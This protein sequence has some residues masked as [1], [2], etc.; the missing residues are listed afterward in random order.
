MAE[1]LVCQDC[2]HAEVKHSADGTVCYWGWA[3][4]LRTLEGPWPCKCRHFRAG[5]AGPAEPIWEL[6]DHLRLGE[7]DRPTPPHEPE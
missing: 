4:W 5:S 1:R 7:L 3:T 2:E 6:P